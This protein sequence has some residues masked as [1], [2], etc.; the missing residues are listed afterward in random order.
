MELSSTEVP[1]IDTEIKRS[2]PIAW[3]DV[4]IETEADK[5][6]TGHGSSNTWYHH[7]ICANSFRYLVH[8]QYDFWGND[9]I[10]IEF[11]RYS[12]SAKAWT[13]V[14]S[15]N[16]LENSD[17]WI[18]VNTKNESGW[19]YTGLDSIHFDIATL[20]QHWG[21]GND[22]GSGNHLYM[23]LYTSMLENSY[24]DLIKGQKI[25]GKKN[26]GILGGVSWHVTGDRPENP[27]DEDWGNIT[28]ARG[29][30]I[31]ASDPYRLIAME[32]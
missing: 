2:D 5:S 17:Q 11:W 15:K 22:K 28:S 1:M 18:N 4:N 7:Y 31:M 16:Y 12:I 19:Q 13:L 27:F 32:D 30:Q 26:T 21:M 9:H 10:Q 25:Y 6:T 24:N 29:S 3:M 8:A 14:N 20:R 23:G